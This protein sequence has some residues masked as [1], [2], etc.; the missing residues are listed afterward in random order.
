MKHLLSVCLVTLTFVAGVP[1]YVV[2]QSPAMQKGISVQLAI[3][4]NANPMPA[5]DQ[6][7]AWVVTITRD[8]SIY[9]GTDKITSEKLH[10]KM[11]RT[12]RR[13]DAK[14]YI[15]SDARAPFARIEKVLDEARVGF[16]VVVFLTSQR[17]PAAPGKIAAPKGLEVS[18]GPESTIGAAVVELLSTGQ[19]LPI[20]K[21]DGHH[22]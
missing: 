6:G 5:A 3:T 4:N 7:D 18:I 10:N 8:G 15:K 2:A 22:I 1:R 19:S 14:F 9:F 21:V 12:P 20:L 16:N 11:K 17:E 13:R